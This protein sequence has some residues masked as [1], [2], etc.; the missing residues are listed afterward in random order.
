M[1]QLSQHVIVCCDCCLFV[2]VFVCV[3]GAS[4]SAGAFGF[5]CE[6][7]YDAL[8]GLPFGPLFV[9]VIVIVIVGL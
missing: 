3:D 5:E 4:V 6:F 2:C 7:A 8:N 1:S 9:A